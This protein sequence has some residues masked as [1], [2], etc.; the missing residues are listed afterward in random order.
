VR[1]VRGSPAHRDPL[2]RF[3]HDGHDGYNCGMTERVTTISIYA[4]DLER[5][6]SHQLRISEGKGKWLTMPEIVRGLINAAE[7]KAEA[8]E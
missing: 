5:L 7:A 1:L 2:N 6:K 3:R 8:G 4:S